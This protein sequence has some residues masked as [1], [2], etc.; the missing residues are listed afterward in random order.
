M[1][2]FTEFNEKQRRTIEAL[3]SFFGNDAEALYETHGR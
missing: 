3:R 1:T 2:A